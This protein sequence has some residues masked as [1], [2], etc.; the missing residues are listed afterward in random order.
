VGLLGYVRRGTASS[1]SW[2]KVVSYV[3]SEG[4]KEVCVEKKKPK[5]KKKNQEKTEE[6]E[7]ES[8]TMKS[9]HE[10]DNGGGKKGGLSLVWQGPPLPERRGRPMEAHERLQRGTFHQER[11]HRWKKKKRIIQGERL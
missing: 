5:E 11:L 8:E 3:E 10:G 7:T 9:C 2:K 6:G 1:R 4:K